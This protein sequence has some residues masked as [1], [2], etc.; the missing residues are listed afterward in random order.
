MTF[1]FL[2]VGLKLSQKDP[3][4]RR[5]CAKWLRIQPPDG[6]AVRFNAEEVERKNNDWSVR[7]YPIQSLHLWPIVLA[8]ACFLLY[9]RTF[10]LFGLHVI[11][12][13]DAAI[14]RQVKLV[15]THAT[16]T[17]ICLQEMLM[18]DRLCLLGHKPAQLRAHD[19]QQHFW[20]W[21]DSYSCD[22]LSGQSGAS[23]IQSRGTGYLKHCPQRLTSCV[24]VRASY[25]S[26]QHGQQAMYEMLPVEAFGVVAGNLNDKK[27]KPLQEQD[28]LCRTSSALNFNRWTSSWYLLCDAGCELQRALDWTRV[29][30][31]DFTCCKYIFFA[32]DFIYILLF[33]WISCISYCCCNLS[34]GPHYLYM[35]V[36]VYESLAHML[37]EE[38]KNSHSLLWAVMKVKRTE[39]R[40]FHLPGIQSKCL[41]VHVRFLWK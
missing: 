8:N 29:P 22:C 27:A 4:R 14:R 28:S 38:T 40:K 21:C 17:E 7:A 36:M 35:Y 30:P 11:C 6:Q 2:Q 37:L 1:Q 26:I 25:W 12:L 33:G 9:L 24:K 13:C 31:Q 32:R 3:S 41:F 15:K 10:T 20:G 5:I 23:V 34:L 19:T 16:I 18:Q 39:V